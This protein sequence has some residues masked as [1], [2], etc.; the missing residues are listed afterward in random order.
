MFPLPP[1]FQLKYKEDYVKQ[2]GHYVGVHS[3]REDPKL[4]WFEHA[5]KIQNDRLY[6]EAYHKT[7]SKIHIPADLL[8]VLAAKD[9]QDKVSEIPYR[10]YLHEWTCHPDQND[11]IQAKKAYDLQSDV[12]A[13]AIQL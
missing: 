8:A 4:V 2:K 6:K 13:Y 10:H 9:C 11:C 7:K 3:M 12:S 1:P 5:G